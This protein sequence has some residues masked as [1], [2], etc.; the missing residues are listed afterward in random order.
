MQFHAAFSHQI[1]Q[2]AG[3]VTGGLTDFT[4]PASSFF[5]LDHDQ[6]NTLST[7]F[8]TDLPWR[9]WASGAVLYGSGFL[10]G[11][12]PGHLPAHTTFDLSLGKDL[13]ERLSLSV[14][15]LN[16]TNRRYMLDTSNTFGGTHWADPRQ[17]IVQLRYRFHY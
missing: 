11:N 17:L 13:G 8:Q 12:G 2:G 4:P 6:R 14:T 9:S 3:A 16:M 5:Y 15:A 10:E 1:A 7:G